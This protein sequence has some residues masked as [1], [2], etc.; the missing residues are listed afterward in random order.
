MQI[1]DLNKL[2][3]LRVTSNYWKSY[4]LKSDLALVALARPAS[5]LPSFSF[6]SFSNISFSFPDKSFK[7]KIVKKEVYAANINKKGRQTVCENLSPY[8]KMNR[9]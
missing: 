7:I 2:I 4:I 1:Y 9:L 5:L 6:I 8:S 3:K